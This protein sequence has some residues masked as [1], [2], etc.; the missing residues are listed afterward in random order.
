MNSWSISRLSDRADVAQF[1]SLDS[2][3]IAFGLHYGTALEYGITWFTHGNGNM[4]VKWIPWSL[5]LEAR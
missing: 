1:A 3:V 2:F 5:K 4:Q